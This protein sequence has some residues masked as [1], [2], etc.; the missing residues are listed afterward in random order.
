MTENAGQI[1]DDPLGLEISK[2]DWTSGKGSAEFEA[3]LRNQGFLKITPV[4][5]WKSEKIQV[6]QTVK[7]G[8]SGS[9]KLSSQKI[10]GKS[11]V[12]AKHNPHKTVIVRCVPKEKDKATG[13]VLYTTNLH[14]FA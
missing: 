11:N 7:S 8:A 3:I 5:V 9:A 14:N 10:M 4:A 1:V 2:I 6:Q 13:K 12:Q